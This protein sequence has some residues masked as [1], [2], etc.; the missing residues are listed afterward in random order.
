MRIWAISDLHVDY[1][2]NF[3]WVTR[4]SAH[5]YRQDVL[6]LAGDISDQAALLEK[7]LATLRAKF[8]T[9]LFLPGNHDLWVGRTGGTSSFQAF[10]H[11]RRIADDCGV[12]TTPVK[13]EGTWFIPLLGWYDYSFGTPSQALER[14]WMD[15]RMCQWPEGL[16]PEAVTAHFTALNEPHLT[17]EGGKIISFSHFLPRTDLIPGFV[18]GH[19]KALFPVMG[20]AR[21]EE[22]IRTLQPVVHVYG[23][24]H[25]NRDVRRDGIRYVNNAFGYPNETRITRKRLLRLGDA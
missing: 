3:N 13:L 24:S 7:T 17:I 11:I 18:P 8:H 4:I 5:D 9:V 25:F 23:H 12:V 1:S 10:D 22:Q 20:S 15:F 14:A 19:V 16:D 6:I 21:L 2:E